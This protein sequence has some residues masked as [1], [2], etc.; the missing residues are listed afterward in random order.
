[1]VDTRARVRTYLKY[2]GANVRRI[3]V[4]NRITQEE[5]AHVSGLDPSFLR[6]LG[7]GEANLRFD[8]L[9]R[10]AVALGVEP[11]VLL[12]QAKFVKPKTGRPRQQRSR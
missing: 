10:L 5:F 1:M 2:L 11:A 8:T 4:R 3:R 12:R 6:Q 7:R 9:V